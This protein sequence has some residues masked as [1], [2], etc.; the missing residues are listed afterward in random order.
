MRAGP[1]ASPASSASASTGASSAVPACQRA[2]PLR[3]CSVPA[4]RLAARCFAA[5]GE[6]RPAAAGLDACVERAGELGC[7]V[8]AAQAR[9]RREAGQAWCVERQRPA[10][11]G[12]VVRG[13]GGLP[14][15]ACCRRARRAPSCAARCRRPAARCGRA[16]ARRRAGCRRSRPGRGRLSAASGRARCPRRCCAAGS[17]RT[18]PLALS[19]CGPRRQDESSRPR[20]HSEGSNSA[21]VARPCS[22]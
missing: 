16:A 20:H 9:Q 6:R 19:W 7:G 8:A 4:R 12:A 18:L 3:S 5:R 2:V 10:V 14:H 21:S 11:V 22:C 13:A 1:S 15:P 17:G